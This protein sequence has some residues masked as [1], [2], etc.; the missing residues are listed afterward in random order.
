MPAPHG[1]ASDSVPTAMK[2]PSAASVYLRAHYLEAVHAPAPAAGGLPPPGPG[3][4]LLASL[5]GP[6]ALPD[7]SDT[8]RTVQFIAPA[9]AS[10]A[11]RPSGFAALG[12]RSGGGSGAS[13]PSRRRSADFGGGGAS[14]AMSAPSLDALAAAL[15]TAPQLEGAVSRGSPTSDPTLLTPEAR[16]LNILAHRATL[17]QAKPLDADAFLSQLY[18][19]VRSNGRL[20]P[21]DRLGGRLGAPRPIVA[22][23]PR[24]SSHQDF[25]FGPVTAGNRAG[26]YRRADPGYDVLYDI[27]NARPL[28]AGKWRL[29]LAA[30]EVTEDGYVIGALGI[31]GAA[32]TNAHLHVRKT[33]ATQEAEAAKRTGRAKGLDTAMAAAAADAA[34]TVAA[35]SRRGGGGGGGS[36][37]SDGGVDDGNDMVQAVITN[38]SEVYVEQEWF[39]LAF[40]PAVAILGDGKAGDDDAMME[41][42]EDGGGSEDEGKGAHSG[43]ESGDDGGSSDGGSGAEEGG[44]GDGDGGGRVPT[45][46]DA[47]DSS[48]YVKQAADGATGGNRR[49]TFLQAHAPFAASRYKVEKRGVF[50]VRI[51]QEPDAAPLSAAAWRS[52]AVTS[53]ALMQLRASAVM[54]QGQAAPRRKGAAAAAAATAAAA[55]AG[56]GGGGSPVPAEQLVHL[57]RLGREEAAAAAGMRYLAHEAAKFAHAPA[58]YGHRLQ[59]AAAEVAHDYDAIR[60]S[61]HRA[62]AA[63][64]AS[65]SPALRAALARERTRGLPRSLSM[66]A[67]GGAG[68]GGG[69][70]ADE[71]HRCTLC[72]SKVDHSM[73]GINLCTAT[74][75]VAERLA[76]DIDTSAAAAVAG[77]ATA[78]ARLQRRASGV[79]SDDAGAAAAAAAAAGAAAA[80]STAGSPTP[81]TVAWSL[82]SHRSPPGS[83]R[84]GLGTMRGG[85]GGGGVRFFPSDAASPTARASAGRRRRADGASALR[86]PTS[87]PGSMHSLPS[88]KPPPPSGVEVLAAGWEA[89]YVAGRDFASAFAD[90]DSDL[91]SIVNYNIQHTRSV[92][93]HSVRSRAT[94]AA[95]GAVVGGGG[96]VRAEGGAAHGGGAAAG[97]SRS[98]AVTGRRY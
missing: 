42:E 60:G 62:T 25:L 72:N 29:Q 43:G 34:A 10:D 73:F 12:G 13:S 19:E 45:S 4:S 75:D 94:A 57:L 16:L 44:D 11:A 39:Y 40:T 7:A 33:R 96:A 56:G 18:K 1:G 8:R 70:S 38:T 92:M 64:V 98:P 86:S 95:A 71:P 15:L 93:E 58:F 47:V 36:G 81:G 5:S 21:L 20:N 65:S 90:V 35:A 31:E 59:L 82:G 97:A 80:I 88:R 23:V 91:G 68:G 3:A 46:V 9:G 14:A 50:R 52:D 83:T 78:V 6:P 51:M 85:G 32:D 87:S 37:G 79:V 89:T 77:S 66:R 84:T 48:L 2:P 55:A 53:R 74:T 24:P 63:A 41:A 67:R 28:V 76:A 22:H 30:K 27:A 54:R 69:G 61:A 49:Q 26:M 17:P